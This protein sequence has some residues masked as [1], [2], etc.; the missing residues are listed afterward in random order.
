MV[1]L[2]YTKWEILKVG[3]QECLGLGI[4]NKFSI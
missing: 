4:L 1:V 3:R 2:R